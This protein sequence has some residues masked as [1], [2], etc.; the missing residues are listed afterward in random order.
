MASVEEKPELV[1]LLHDRIEKTGGISFAEF[2][3]QCLYHP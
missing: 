3:E 1:A 2:M